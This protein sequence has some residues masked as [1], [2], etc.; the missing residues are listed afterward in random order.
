MRARSLSQVAAT[1]ATPPAAS[2]EDLTGVLLLLDP[3]HELRSLAAGDGRVAENFHGL[4]FVDSLSGVAPGYGTLHAAWA[5]P[6]H[7]A[8]HGLLIAAAAGCRHVALLPL[9]RSGGLAGVYN[10]G[11]RGG[12]VGFATLE[13]AWMEHVAAQALVS[14]ERLLLRARLLRAGVV[15]PLTG[16]NSR[17]YFMAR[18]RE[19]VGA[20]ARR[21]EPATCLVIDVDGL[22][23]LNDR[24]GVAA[25]D[26]ALYE[27]GTLIEAQIRAS[28][29]FSHLG[30]DEF[31]ALLPATSPLHASRLAE[32][33]LSAVRAAPVE[34]L[35]GRESPLRISIGIAGLDP[36]GLVSGADTKATADEWIARARAALYQAK[37]A[38]GDRWVAA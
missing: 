30:E 4:R 28:D 36:S 17:H 7:A 8:D 11:S 5:G 27:V 6:Y 32:R 38:G 9:P 35:P 12:P 31:A 20:S 2:D 21:A 34:P 13:P 10:I 3:R 24:E 16:W 26:A 19:Q 18:V 23:Q 14:T 37:L 29:S 25:G 22:G 15:D 1:L 33:I